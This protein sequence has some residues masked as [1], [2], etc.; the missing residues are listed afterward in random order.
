MRALLCCIA[1]IALLASASGAQSTKASAR[2]WASF[3]AGFGPAGASKDGDAVYEE[4]GQVFGLL[5]VTRQ[6]AQSRALEVAVL[7]VRPFGAGD[8]LAIPGFVCA[9]PFGALGAS[10]TLLTSL[11]GTIAPDR[12]LAGLGAGVFRVAPVESHAVSPRPALGLHVSVDV[13]VV[14]VKRS[15]L[16]LG[17]RG[18][19]FP[20]VHGQTL[21]MGLLNATIRA[22]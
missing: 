6:L 12:F 19:V 10:T 15:A 16:A 5:G 22:W 17:I 20:A 4:S 21:W 13:P 18:H 2:T 3:S 9:P 14:V 11:G 8:C 7:G 1:T